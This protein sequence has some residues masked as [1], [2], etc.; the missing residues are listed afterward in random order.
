VSAGDTVSSVTGVQGVSGNQAASFET[1]ISEYGY[2]RQ[3][4]TSD[5]TAKWFKA[6]ITPV[7]SL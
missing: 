2:I 7:G 5:L 4:S 1:V 3:L 6:L